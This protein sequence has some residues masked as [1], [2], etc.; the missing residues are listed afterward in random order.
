[1]KEL[2]KKLATKALDALPGILGSIVSWIFSAA[3]KVVGFM[4][5]HL[6]T[7]L[8]LIVGLLLSKIKK[9]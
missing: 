7:L 4:A 8:V 2:L 9:T 6:W 5:E 3:S 1:M